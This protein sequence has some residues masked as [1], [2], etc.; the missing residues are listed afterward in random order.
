VRGEWLDKQTWDAL[1]QAS[2][3]GVAVP[4]ATAGRAWASSSSA[5]SAR[6]IGRAVAQVPVLA[7]LVLGAPADRALRQR[8]AEEGVAPRRRG[9]HDDPHRRAHRGRA[10]RSGAPHAHG[11]AR[12]AP[13]G[14]STARRSSC[15][16]ASSRRAFSCPATTGGHDVG[17]FLV[18][19][20]AA[21]VTLERQVLTNGEPH[22]QSRR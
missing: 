10:R 12:T 18:D 22:A 9:W 15:P 13:D 1:A 7:S 2:L 8:R 4:E 16:R 14:S 19:P 21:G 5:S 17:V 3:L 20:K 11:V 6:E